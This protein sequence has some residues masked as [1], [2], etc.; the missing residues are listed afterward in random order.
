MNGLTKAI[1]VGASA[2]ALSASAA[3]AAIVCNDDGECWHTKDPI[4]N[5]SLDSMFIPII[6]GGAA[7]TT[8]GGVNTKATDTGVAAHGW[9]SDNR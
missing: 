7:R 2:L 6:G 4:S 5:P 8:T 9:K 1:L 3:S